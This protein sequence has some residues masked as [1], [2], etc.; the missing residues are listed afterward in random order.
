MVVD[1][2][3]AAKDL[4]VAVVVLSKVRRPALTVLGT[5]VLSLQVSSYNTT[6]QVC[7]MRVYYQGYLGVTPT[8]SDYC[9]YT[10]WCRLAPCLMSSFMVVEMVMVAERGRHSTTLTLLRAKMVMVPV[11]L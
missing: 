6:L 1:A 2:A 7:I 8:V 10:S 5:G 3:G 9:T 4:E 11:A